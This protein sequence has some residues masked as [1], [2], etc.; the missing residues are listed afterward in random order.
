MTSCD[1]DCLV[2]STTAA[3]R[4]NAVLVDARL[5]AEVVESGID[6]A[7]PLLGLNLLLFLRIV[8]E[9]IA[10]TFSVAAIVKSKSVN[11]GSAELRGDGLPCLSIAVAH[12]QQ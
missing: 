4:A 9:A 8:L 7:G 6:V 11:S 12:V 3:A 5:F 2:H 1:L 10:A